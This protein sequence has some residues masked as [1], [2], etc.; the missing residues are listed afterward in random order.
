MPIHIFWGDD[1]SAI[2]R[3]TERILAKFV[4]PNWGNFNVSRFNGNE[5]IESIRSLEEVR[6]LPLGTGGKVVILKRSP[7]CNGCPNELATKLDAVLD[8]IP[9]PTHFILQNTNK[10][11][12]RLK[13]TKSIQKVIK[14]SNLSSEKSFLL[15]AIWDTNGQKQIVEKIASELNLQLEQNAIIS[16]VE[17]VGNDTTRIYAELEKLSLLAE[18]KRGSN[19]FKSNEKQKITN[20]MVNSLISGIATNA[21]DIAN[22]LIQGKVGGALSRIDALLE[23][24]EPALRIV[25]TLTGQVRGCLW[26]KLLDEKGKEDVSVIAKQAGIANP[27]RIYIIRKQIQGKSA[28][29]FLKLLSNLLEIE[30]SIKKGANPSNSFKDSLLTK[31]L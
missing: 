21:L 27:K 28:K 8:V 31:G 7:F 13:T 20:E 19:V 29:N 1:S 22:Y 3:E 16:L 14:L 23:N 6:N 24:G 30:A 2:N 10:P 26:V 5:T 17:S 11:D 9:E 12:K 15:P 25:A 4:D 18:A